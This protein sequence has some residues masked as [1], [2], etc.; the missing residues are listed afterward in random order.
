MGKSVQRR[1]ESKQSRRAT[2]EESLWLRYIRRRRRR[3]ELHRGGESR[4]GDR[5]GPATQVPTRHVWTISS[6]NLV[7]AQRFSC[8]DGTPSTPIRSLQPTGLARRLPSLRFPRGH[9]RLSSKLANGSP[10]WENT[11]RAQMVKVQ[12][13]TIATNIWASKIRQRSS[14]RFFKIF[15]TPRRLVFFT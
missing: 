1:I 7:F 15:P 12:T 4:N 5:A 6:R 8:L 3:A 13:G 14:L 10:R 2:T 11:T 9:P